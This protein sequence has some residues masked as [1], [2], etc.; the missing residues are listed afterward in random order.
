MSGCVYIL[1]LQII[2]SVIRWQLTLNSF[3]SL[4]TLCSHL[5]QVTLKTKQ[6]RV[7]RSTSWFMFTKGHSYTEWYTNYVSIS[8]LK[9]VFTLKVFSPSLPRTHTNTHT[10]IL[11][12]TDVHMYYT[13]HYNTTLI[14]SPTLTLT[15][16]LHSACKTVATW[17]NPHFQNTLLLWIF[18]TKFTDLRVT[19]FHSQFWLL[20]VIVN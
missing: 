9:C 12:H 4:F 5:L 3:W 7:N 20:H 6:D 13:K 19:K 1:V 16:L 2:V 14:Y 10:H 15:W 11:I 8:S 18:I 17:K